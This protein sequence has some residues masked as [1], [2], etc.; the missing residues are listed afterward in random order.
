MIKPERWKGRR[1]LR[2]ESITTTG[3]TNFLPFDFN[4]AND[5]GQLN[6]GRG[7]KIEG[8]R[9]NND[10]GEGVWRGRGIVIESLESER[11]KKKIEQDLPG[12]LNGLI[13][14]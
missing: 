14:G 2:F 11:T 8:R 1:I 10:R 7:M 12:P 4:A 6:E 5:S 13:A 3:R 9:R